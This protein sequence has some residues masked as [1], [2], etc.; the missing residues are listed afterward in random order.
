MFTTDHLVSVQHWHRLPVHPV[1]RA[2]IR[3]GLCL[4]GAIAGLGSIR[5]RRGP[6]DRIL[7]TAVPRPSLLPERRS[8]RR[9]ARIATAGS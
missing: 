2:G 1:R 7:G 4:A 3:R 9:V 5:P 8:E 6:A